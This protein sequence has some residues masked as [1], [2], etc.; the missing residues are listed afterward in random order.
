MSTNTQHWFC[1]IGPV[2]QGQVSDI[3][4]RNE[5]EA[6]LKI[7]GVQTTFIFSGFDCKLPERE[8]AVVENRKPSHENYIAFCEREEAHRM[9]LV[10]KDCA[11]E[12]YLP[13]ELL[14]KVNKIIEVA[15][16]R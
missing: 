10:L 4:L 7:H 6:F 11:F 9:L 15:E 3:M 12:G 1:K 13:S 16:G 2:N 8:Q 5:L 14:Q